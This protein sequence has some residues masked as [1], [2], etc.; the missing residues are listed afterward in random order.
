MERIIVAVPRLAKR[1][2]RIFH[3]MDAVAS[4]KNDQLPTDDRT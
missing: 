1:I 4:L 3:A 2:A